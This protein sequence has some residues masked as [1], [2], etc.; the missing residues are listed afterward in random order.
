MLSQISGQY[1]P[2]QGHDV[3]HIIFD[4]IE[5]AILISM[6]VWLLKRTFRHPVASLVFI[7][8]VT[9]TTAMSVHKQRFY[10]L[11]WVPLTIALI[12]FGRVVR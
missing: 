8:G 11:V 3:K 7:G 5:N 9:A 10:P 6:L 2:S 1:E 4:G 12:A